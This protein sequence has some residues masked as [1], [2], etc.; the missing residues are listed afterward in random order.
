MTLKNNN[1]L[2]LYIEKQG[3]GWRFLLTASKY[4]FKFIDATG[5]VSQIDIYYSYHYICAYVKFLSCLIVHL[6][7]RTNAAQKNIYTLKM[8]SIKVDLGNKGHK[9]MI[10]YIATWSKCLEQY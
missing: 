3:V 9:K 10:L 6:S 4:F 1:T 8:K 2:Q 7:S 5:L